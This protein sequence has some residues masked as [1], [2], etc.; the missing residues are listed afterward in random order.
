PA[1]ARAGMKAISEANP[2]S[3]IAGMLT[4][5]AL[6]GA[7]GEGAVAGAGARWAPRIADAAY[8]AAYGAGSADEG[9]RLSG[10]GWGS[11]AGLLGG[12]SG[13]RGMSAIG[14][15]LQGVRNQSAQYLRERGVPL[16]IGQMLGGARKA[17]EDRLAGYAGVGDQIN[18]QRRGGIRAFNQVAF[19]DGLAPISQ[20]SL[21]Q[22]G[23]EGVDTARQAISGP[24]GAYS[25]ALNGVSLVPDA[26]FQS[27][28]A[29]ALV[30]GRNVARTG[31]EFDSFVQNSVAPHF[32]SPNGQ[33]DGRQVQDILQ[34]VRGADFGSDSMG[35]LA[36]DATRDIEGAVMDLAGRQAPGSMEALGNA[37]TAYR[38][39]NI[40]ADAVGRGINNDGMFMPSQLGAAAKANTTKFGGKIA[41]ATPSRPFYELQRAGQKVLPSKVPDSGTAGRIEQNGGITAALRSGVRNAVN[42][43]LY[44]DSMQE[45]IARLLMDRSPEMVR[46]GEIAAERA[47]IAGLLSRPASLAYGPLA[48]TP[49]Y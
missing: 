5:G 37:N 3:S 27:D 34:Q 45:P 13:R 47:R 29:A 39:L 20:Q 15:G 10:A 35:A 16:T 33:I 36:S 30:R 32:S 41:A 40:L 12:E 38:N 6:S 21:N 44:A 28:V 25:Q 26:P 2:G 7:L 46:L 23:E 17:K 48:V 11:V 1:L 31:P 4:G 8:G 49:D 42:A 9:D 14:S 18:A 22:V 43:P 19:D 24:N